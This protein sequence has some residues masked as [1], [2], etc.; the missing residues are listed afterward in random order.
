MG[1]I[2]Y[3]G[4]GRYRNGYKLVREELVND[5]SFMFLSLEVNYMF[6]LEDVFSFVIKLLGLL[7]KR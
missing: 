3:E 2:N 5:I 1:F 4:D 6:F 7:E